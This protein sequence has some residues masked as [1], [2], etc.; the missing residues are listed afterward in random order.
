LKKGEQKNGLSWG[1]RCSR[2]P[3][4]MKIKQGNVLKKG[5]NTQNPGKNKQFLGGGRTE[6][7]LCQKKL[8]LTKTKKTTREYTLQLV[9]T[10]KNETR[11]GIGKEDENPSKKSQVGETQN[12]GKEKKWSPGRIKGGVNQNSREGENGKRQLFSHVR[13]A[14]MRAA[15]ERKRGSRGERNAGMS[16]SRK[17]KTVCQNKARELVLGKKVVGRRQ[18][19]RGGNQMGVV[20]ADATRKS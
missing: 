8:K 16:S 10:E 14:C 2:L 3:K 9:S 1:F 4:P 17:K 20:T 7:K 15:R 11:E 12:K 19:T 13:Y 5:K 18:Q 6:K